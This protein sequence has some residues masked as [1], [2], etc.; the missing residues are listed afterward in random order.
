[1][2]ACQRITG[3]QARAAVTTRPTRAHAWTKLFLALRSNMCILD[4]FANPKNMWTVRWGDSEARSFLIPWT[5]Y[6]EEIHFCSHADL[7]CNTIYLQAWLAARGRVVM[8]Q[9]QRLRLG[10]SES[11]WWLAASP[12]SLQQTEWRGLI[13]A[14]CHGGL[15]S[16]G[17]DKKTYGDSQVE[18]R[19][20][21]VKPATHSLE[22]SWRKDKS[23]AAPG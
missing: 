23:A 9:W 18:K 11:S 13:P 7:C 4:M 12:A 20:N 16:S 17:W 14:C 21:H 8:T 2:P 10:D 3:D 15:T 19:P 1:M 5:L 22:S 6:V